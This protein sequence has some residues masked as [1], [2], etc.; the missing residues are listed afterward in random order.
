LRA[1]LLATLATGKPR[2]REEVVLPR[3]GSG[4]DLVLLVSAVPFGPVRSGRV[5]ISLE[6]ITEHR[7]V[8]AAL[9]A[10][11][12]GF[13]DVVERI[14]IGLAVVDGRGVVRHAN[15]AAAHMLRRRRSRMVGRPL[16]FPAPAGT[17]AEVEL[18]AG[19]GGRRI[20]ELQ[21]VR[22]RWEGR[23]AVLVSLSDRTEHRA[24]DRA[25][26]ESQERLALVIQGSNDGIWDWD[27]RSN[28]VYFS[29]RW[30]GML[31][32]AEEEVA[33]TFE[34]WRKLLHPEDHD[35][36]LAT[37][38][39][40]FEGRSESYEL[41]HR[42]RHKDGSY[43]WILA[44]G[45]ALRDATGRPIRMAGS[46]VD[47]TGRKQAEERLRAVCG[48]LARSE[49]DLRRTVSQLEQANAELTSAQMHLVHAAKMESVGTLAAGVA[50]EVKN[51]LQVILMGLR[52]LDR[53]SSP[54]LPE[55]RAVIGDM[56]TAV[57]RAD[58]IV[59]GLLEFSS[60]H[61]LDLAS[62]SLNKIVRKSLDLVRYELVKSHVRV[63]EDFSSGLPS[64]M[65]D[66]LK[67][68]QVVVNLLI[69]AVHAMPSGGTLTVRTSVIGND[70]GVCGDPPG[71][72]K[73]C[74]VVL[75]IEDEGPGIPAGSLP[76]VFDPFFTTKPLGGGTGLGLTVAKRIVLL[77]GGDIEL[78]N[79]PEGGACAILRFS[80]GVAHDGQPVCQN[81]G[82]DI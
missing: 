10:S 49:D 41:E 55:T 74:D 61:Q 3:D 24:A 63:R 33:S 19:G 9:K 22:S 14:Q 58:A 81:E 40:Y 77:H 47:L 70:V 30:K 69:N 56:R 25:L 48:D 50:H 65:L 46:H 31:G 18:P 67:I 42:L 71:S 23:P 80:S 37:L 66:R 12:A 4:R 5:L 54:D 78:R 73:S 35:R 76:R 32:Y 53:A 29:P 20:V 27:V 34:G 39:D 36:A 8:E 62:E 52:Y 17:C 51:P 68:E 7:R 2:M 75:Q 72:W 60:S 21:A 57:H 26:R 82:M 16:G 11:R 44:R 59:R 1:L 43:R 28:E 45:V 13:H 38:Q 15:P 6:D 79:R 64:L